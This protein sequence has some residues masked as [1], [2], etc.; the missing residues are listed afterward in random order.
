MF[1]KRIEYIN[2]LVSKKRVYDLCCD[3][4]FIGELSLKE[5]RYVTFID[6]ISDITEAL[7]KNLLKKF[8]RSS[9]SVIT[10]SILEIKELES[11]STIILAGVGSRL[12]CEFLQYIHPMLD[13]S[14]ELIVCVHSNQHMTY[15]LL[16]ELKITRVED[17]MLLDS[18]KVYEIFKCKK[19]SNYRENLTINSEF[20]HFKNTQYFKKQLQ[21]YKHK[22]QDSYIESLYRQL[23]QI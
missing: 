13:E 19:L 6:Q 18:G 20:S 1:S 8:D 4:G 12:F 3:H 21:F 10:S 23:L 17:H 16:N 5:N 11:N 22:A 15:K 14:H 7:N 2:S 9:F